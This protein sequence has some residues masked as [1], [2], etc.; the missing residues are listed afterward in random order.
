M[1]ARAIGAFLIAI[2]L[3]TGDLWAQAPTTNNSPPPTPLT[4]AQ[5][6]AIRAIGSAVETKA[7]PVAMQLS[8]VVS[9]VY[10]NNLSETPNEDLRATL[11][12]QM[13]ELVWQ[14]LQLKG[15]A[16]W[17]A[18]R[19]LTPEQKAIV[20]ADVAAPRTPGDL[21]DVLDIIARRFGPLT[22]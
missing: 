9:K 1:T 4:D 10:E 21:P 2:T 18:F 22:K 19:V 11:S 17:A 5:K 15:E 20:R 14:A 8:A 13:K 3:G 7:L 16:M 6:E 12:G